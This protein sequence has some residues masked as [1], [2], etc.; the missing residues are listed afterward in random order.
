M[1]F[2]INQNEYDSFYQYYYVYLLIQNH[3]KKKQVKEV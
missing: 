3:C 2:G 1:E